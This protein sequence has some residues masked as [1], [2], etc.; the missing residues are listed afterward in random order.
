MNVDGHQF[1]IDLNDELE[2]FAELFIPTTIGRSFWFNSV[3]W[4]YFI[5]KTCCIFAK[6][7]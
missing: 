1:N 6:V 2:N 5:I 3:P 7:G 4:A